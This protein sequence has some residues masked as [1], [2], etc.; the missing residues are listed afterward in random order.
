LF[1]DSTRSA[2]ELFWNYDQ[3]LAV[4]RSRQVP[5]APVARLGRLVEEF[6][7]PHECPWHT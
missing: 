3:I 1:A 2:E 6:R 5:G 4:L 7:G